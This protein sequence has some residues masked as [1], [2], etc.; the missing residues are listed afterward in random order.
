MKKSFGQ[1]IWGGFLNFMMIFMVYGLV[2]AAVCRFS[3]VVQHSRENKTFSPIY[4][5]RRWQ[6]KERRVQ[7][8]ESSIFTSIYYQRGSLV[9]FVF[10]KKKKKI[11]FLFI[12]NTSGHNKTI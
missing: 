3:G 8:F 6:E 12:D 1:V 11:T 10:R 7:L 2:A 9:C 4:K 5:R